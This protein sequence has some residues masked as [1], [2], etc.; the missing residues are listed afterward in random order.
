M[1][2]L[3][4]IIFDLHEAISE[5]EAALSEQSSLR[6]ELITAKVKAE[7]IDRA[8]SIL[9]SVN[10]SRCPQCGSDLDSHRYIPQHCNLCGTPF[11]EDDSSSLD[12]EIVRRELNDRIDQLADSINRRKQALKRSFRYLQQVESEKRKLD[13][14]LQEELDRY[15]SV[16]VERVRLVESKVAMLR[17]RHNSLIQLQEMPRAISELEERAGASQGIIDR[18]RSKIE[19]ER[20]RLRGGDKNAQ[21]IAKEMKKVMLEVGFPGVAQEDTVKLDPRNWKPNVVHSEQS[22]G[23]WDTGS[24]GKKTL[25]NIC[26]ALAVHRI[27]RE[28]G[29]PLPNILIIDS[30]TKNISEDENPDLVKSLYRSIYKLA[31]SEI[32]IATQFLLIDSDLVEPEF[33]LSGFLPHRM[34]GD[35]DAPSL[36]SYYSGP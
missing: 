7:R 8:S 18:L 24:G 9:E 22:W 17:E 6:A 10:Y 20:G 13:T 21:I 26:Y 28:R 19:E 3:S 27:S 12:E 31:S 25:F 23:F 15:D 29:L 33:E 32:H 16:F 35:Q 30:P 34:A 2:E 4:Q 1:R 36:I 5:S 11:T 14:Q